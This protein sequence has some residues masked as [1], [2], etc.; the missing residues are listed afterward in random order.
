MPSRAPFVSPGPPTGTMTWARAGPLATRAGATLRPRRR[1]LPPLSEPT[2][3][4]PSPRRL[5][6]APSQ[7]VEG[8]P[9]CD[10]GSAQAGHGLALDQREIDLGADARGGRA[11]RQAVLVDHDI[12]LEPILV[13]AVRQ[14]HF[15]IGRVVNRAGE[16][17]LC[18]VVQRIA[19][20]VHF[21]V[22]MKGLG[23][24]RGL[25]YG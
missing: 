9:C 6:A 25:D 4:G 21:V 15:E 17:Q 20:V 5:A 2:A 16:M 1:R 11:M 19:A 14:Q 13:R 8:P 10:W 24:L 7:A 23:L 3:P 12:I 22:H 18:H